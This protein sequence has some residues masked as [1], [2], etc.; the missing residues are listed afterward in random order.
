MNWLINSRS[1]LSNQI[2]TN[3][4]ATKIYKAN[5]LFPHLYLEHYSL[6]YQAPAL[7]VMKQIKEVG[8]RTS[9]YIYWR[10]N[11]TWEQRYL[12]KIVN[13]YE[14]WHVCPYLTCELIKEMMKKLS[15]LFLSLL[16]LR[17]INWNIADM[18]SLLYIYIYVCTYYIYIYIIYI[19]YIYL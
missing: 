2:S 7:L 13:F 9:H 19:L 8:T 15:L 14:T 3:K 10:R 1:T 4:N 11:K 17:C 16:L 18:L 12:F 5:S 6:K